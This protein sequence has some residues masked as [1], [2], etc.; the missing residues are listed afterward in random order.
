MSKEISCSR[1]QIKQ[2]K[3][4]YIMCV[5]VF[6]CI[7]YCIRFINKIKHTLI[8]T[9]NVNIIQYNELY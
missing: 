7:K 8:A 6:L 2:S 9:L 1:I 5:C 4:L 3:Q